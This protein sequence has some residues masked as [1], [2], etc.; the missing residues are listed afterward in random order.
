MKLNHALLAAVA[1]GAIVAPNAQAATKKHAK[2]HVKAASAEPRDTMLKGEVEELK[3]QVALL[4]DELRAQRDTTAATQT[5]V[6]QTQ[7]QVGSLNQQIAA[8]P[9][10]TKDDVKAVAHTEIATAVEKEHHNDTFYFKGIKI[11]PGGFLELAGIYRDHNQ[12][13]DIATSF[14]GIPFPNAHNYYEGESR[15]TARQS[16]VSFL[17]EGM[18]NEHTK[19]SMY[20]EFDFQGAAQTAN[21]NE[22][23]SYNPRIRNLYGTV[24]YNKDGTGLHFLAGQNWSLITMQSKGITPRSE[25]IPLVIDAQY[26]PGFA[27]TRT[28]QVRFTADFLDHHLWIAASA[29]NPQTT[30]GGTVPATVTNVVAGGSGFNSANSLSLNTVPDFIGKVAYDDNIAGHQVHIEG[31]GLQRTFTARINGSATVS[32]SNVNRG[33]ASFG[34][35]INVQLVPQYLDVQFSG[36]TGKGIGRYGAGSLP[37]VTFDSNGAIT[38]IHETIMLAGLVLHPSKMLDVYG[39]A[40]QETERATPLTGAY[41]IGNLLANDSGCYTE[42]GTCGGN[43]RR[44]RQVTGGLWQKIYN[45]SFGRAQVGLQYSYTQRDLFISANSNG[46]PSTDQSIG[47]ISFRYYPF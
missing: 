32:G 30:F 36:M 31:F 11:T 38:P 9:P 18:A 16:R 6:A 35:G 3:A 28:P 12:T 19:L 17:A 23:N 26:V 21:S 34:G 5:Q 29:E 8:A 14:S 7:A 22:S 25:V 27:W 45:G 20:G 40:G 44:V 42:G 47:M 46:V 39:Y 2:H 33:A 41:G 1:L 13:N 10:M 43:T 37:D 4:R 15:M 24:D